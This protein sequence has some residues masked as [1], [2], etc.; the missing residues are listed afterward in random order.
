MEFVTLSWGAALL[1][2]LV[3]TLAMT[4]FWYAARAA[5]WMKLDW[6]QLLGSF[7]LPP[8]QRA[9]AVG[10]VWHFLSGLVYGLVY[11]Y[12]LASTD[13]PLTLGTG[14]ALGLI[15]AVVALG[16][17]W[18]LPRVHPILPDE[19][20]PAI[21]S[22]RDLTLYALGFPIFGAFFGG[23][24]AWY[25]QSVTAT[26]MEPVRFWMTVFGVFAIALVVGL[27]GYVLI[28]RQREEQAMVFASSQ[29]TAEEQIEALTRLYEQGD[30]TEDEYRAELAAIEE[31]ERGRV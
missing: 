24:Y 20:A 27:A 1:S 26:G 29:L 5:G 10:L 22:G 21:W 28:S 8:G 7:F 2:G 11:A 9:L 17:I 12:I 25:D 30:L 6:G 31:E 3:G 14:L 4:V 18:F 23:T 13:Q 19:N 15:H 16:L